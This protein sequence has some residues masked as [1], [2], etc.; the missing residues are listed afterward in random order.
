M[1]ASPVAAPHHRYRQ[2][3][4]YEADVGKVLDR[5]GPAPPRQGW[6][7]SGRL[8]V[9]RHP[10]LA[11]HEG[12]PPDLVLRWGP[13][14]S[15]ATVD[16]VV[17]LHG[18]WP[19]GRRMHLDRDME[20]RSGLD[21]V[22]P[23]RPAMVGRTAPTLLVLPRGHFHGGRSG[24][25]YSFPALKRPKA[26][27]ALVDDALGRFSA[28]TGVRATRGR[29]ILTAHSGGGAALMEILR[30]IDPDEVHTFDAL[31]RDP[32]PLIAWAGRRQA[33]GTGALRV[34]FRP[35][36]ATAVNSLRV[37]AAIGTASPRFRVEETMVPHVAVPRT[38]GWRLLADPAADLPGAVRPGSRPGSGGFDMQQHEVPTP[39][40][41][42]PS[43]PAVPPL[44]AAIARV[45]IEEFRRWRPGG[46][47]AL[48]ERSP[49]AS[50]ILLEYYRV[51]VNKTVITDTQM[52]NRAYQE[53]HPWSAV[54]VSYVMRKAGAVPPFTPSVLDQHLIVAARR[55]RLNNDTT[56][57]FWLF[58]ATEA[59]AQVGDLVCVALEGR[60]ATYDNIGE[61]VLRKTRCDVVTDVRPGRI[62]VVGGDVGGT[63]QCKC[64]RTLPGGRLSVTGDQSRIFAV[65][66]CRPPGASVP[67]PR[68][69]R[70]TGLDARVLRVMDLLVTQYGFPVI[71]AAG[72]VGNLIAES[73]VLPNMIEGNTDAARPMR[74]P[75]FDGKVRDFKPDEVRGRNERMR[76]G[77]QLAGVGI[78]QWTFESRRSGLFRHTFCGQQLGSAILFDL[79]A[80]VDYIDTE[81]RLPE[82]S[83]VRAKLMAPGLTV[84]QACDAVLLQYENPGSVSG[85]KATAATRRAEIAKRRPLAVQALQIYRAAR[86][87]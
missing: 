73:K 5:A 62:R 23:A 54:F 74:A 71:A 30:H 48:T 19:Q 70:P 27:P 85:A 11:T 45:A 56:N 81:M 79:D 29:L 31:Y 63:V 38:Y 65:I 15:S 83:R 77:P 42:V 9:E 78:V 26:L 6:V 4:A 24:Q 20:P 40:P 25:G 10:Q 87:T 7:Q 18:H 43:L 8:V 50:P 64:L 47:P 3:H 53:A 34:L 58:R 22:D 72:I 32:G 35:G 84:E 86:G 55:N 52:Q 66:R 36:E 37:A 49:A 69:P 82:Y 41:A 57:P 28:A 76:W 33:A 61:A 60:G 39:A 51:G 16:V 1:T 14:P 75:D 21:L 44:C 46:G 12:V 59:V 80:Q 13:M 68:L 67:T 2:P 17:H